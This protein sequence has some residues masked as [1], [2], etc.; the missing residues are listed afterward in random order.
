M[1]NW[2]TE[3]HPSELALERWAAGES[4]AHETG[5][6]QSHLEACAVCR[7]REVEWRGLFLA[8]SSLQGPEPSPSFDDAVMAR[9][10][11]PAEEEV[12]AAAWLHGLARRLRPVVVGAAAAWAATLIGGAAWLQTRLDAPAATLLSGLL[13]YVRQWLL[14]AVLRIGA[15]LE[16]SGIADLWSRTAETVPALGVV[17]AVA[18]MTLVSGFAIWILY[19]VTGYQPSRN[20]V[21]G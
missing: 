20:H 17:G 8:L 12:V 16:L 5:A 7:A 4:E 11:L 19:R 6:I 21:H 18:L 9:L 14:A 1:K 10:R 3:G 13:V 15:F 2:T